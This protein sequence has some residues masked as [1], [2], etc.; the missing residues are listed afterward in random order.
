MQLWP[1]KGKNT[2]WKVGGAVVSEGQ[3]RRG[4]EGL[5]IDGRGEKRDLGSGENKRSKI[6]P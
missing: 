3:K 5:R 1:C 4:K 2:A 6:K